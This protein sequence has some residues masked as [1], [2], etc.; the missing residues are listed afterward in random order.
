[1]HNMKKDGKDLDKEKTPSP[2]EKGE[3]G[4]NDGQESLQPNGGIMQ[5]GIK[6]ETSM[7]GYVHSNNY[8]YTRIGITRPR[9]CYV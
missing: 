8:Q 9:S 6:D 1:M 3:E 7:Y 5:N 4:P 2:F